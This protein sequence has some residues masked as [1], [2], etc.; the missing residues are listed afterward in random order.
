MRVV[1]LRS[2]TGSAEPSR[3]L[4]GTFVG[5]LAL[6]LLALLAVP[7]TL[8]AQ[9]FGRNKVQYDEFDFRV[10]ETRHFDIHFYP[11]KSQAI[12]DVSR[13]SERW[14]ERL[15]R[16]FQHEFDE[17]K[18]L[19]FYA[20]HPD[21][22]QTNTIQGQV[23]QGTGGVAEALK[24]RVIMPMAGTHGGTDHVLGHEL[25]HAFQYDLAQ[26]RRGGGA[27]SLMRLPL[28]L[29]EGMAEYLSVGREDA[30]TAMWMRDAILQDD[31]PT[32]QQMTRDQSYFPY[33]FGQAFFSYVG[34]EY[35]DE[36]VIRYFRNAL[37]GGLEGASEQVFGV[38]YEELAEDWHESLENHYG[39]LMEDRTPPGEV[40]TQLVSSDGDGGT[41]NIAPTLSPDGRYLAFMSERDLFSIDLYLADA[42]TGEV[43]RQMSSSQSDPHYDA[44]R[45][46]ESAGT[47]SPDSEKL[48]Y[49]V[50]SEGQNQIVIQDVESG[51]VLQRIDTDR[52]IGEITTPSWSPD[53]DHI[54]FAGQ[55]RG[56]TDLFE[57]NLETEEVTRLTEDRHSVLQPAHSPDGRYVAFVSDRG[58]ETDFHQLT[59][60]EEQ[61]NLYDLESGDIETLEL[62]GNVRH[63]NPQFSPDGHSIFFLSDQDGFQDLYRYDLDDDEI[64]R[65]TEVA[66][67]VSGITALSP[68]MTVAREAGTVAFSVFENTE[69]SIY[70]LDLQQAEEGSL[71]AEA[72]AQAP[73]RILPPMDSDVP[74][75]VAEYIDDPDTGLP[76]AD[77]YAADDARDYDPSLSLDFVGQPMVGGTVGGPFGSQVGGAASAFFS[78]MLGDRHLGVAVQ[79]QGQLRDIGGQAS[80]SNLKRRW[81]WGVMGG[82]IPA[83]GLRTGINPNAGA[84]DEAEI[85]QDLVRMYTTTAQGM[86]AYPFS[87][88]RRAEFGLGVMRQSF[89]IERQSYLV[90]ETGTPLTNLERRDLDEGV[91]DPL[92]FVQGYAALVGDNSTFGFTSPIQGSRYRLELQQTVGTQ[93]FTSLTAD[94]RRYFNPRTEITLAFRG[95]H[96]G[97]YGSALDESLRTDEGTQF[98]SPTQPLFLG[99]EQLVRGYSARSFREQE[100]GGCGGTGTGAGEDGVLACPAIDRLVGHRIGVANAELR[101]PLL[102]VEQ[103]GIIDVGFLPT[104]LIAFADAGM[105]WDEG[106]YPELSFARDSDRRVPVFS[107]GV[108]ARFNLFGA[109]IMEVYYAKPWQRPDR[110]AHMGFQIAPGW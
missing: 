29:V 79:A 27:Q 38:D 90:D 36:A 107:T 75:R 10:L 74:S 16:V 12:E 33:R 37:R 97:R 51:R 61:I 22:Q 77:Q 21:F 99:N 95:M 67:G 88:T 100:I 8:T 86:T 69:F 40:G 1:P 7:E 54:V 39:P 68:A 14:Y 96:F 48:A 25:V 102:G 23:G 56:V 84:S 5:L 106:D 32:V 60:S 4:A 6:G 58:P 46:M 76:P 105:A 73:G 81:N 59:Y 62:F 66:T 44:L 34:G 3:N 104:E 17:R 65:V 82:R 63:S 89:G 49:V 43:I 70:S 57:L 13:M 94:F 55:A 24:N 110:G 109:L 98:G 45:F 19:I 108:G 26:T 2:E 15:A 31:L 85:F 87:E 80:F 72:E 30:H 53:G 35:G 103:Y 50:F 11:E 41:Q 20:D 42:R 64:N 78:D 52:E 101:I 9:Y 28:W 83:M 91:P 47:W 18:P 92:S 71:V 93:D